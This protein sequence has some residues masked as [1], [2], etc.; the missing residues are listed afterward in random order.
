ML[1]M[2]TR[3]QEARRRTRLKSLLAKERRDELIKMLEAEY[4]PTYLLEDLFETRTTAAIEVLLELYRW[5]NHN[6][7][8]DRRAAY[9]IKHYLNEL[10][11]SVTDTGLQETINRAICERAEQERQFKE[12]CEQIGRELNESIAKAKALKNAIRRCPK[13]G[14]NPT[15]RIESMDVDDSW[16]THYWKVC[17]KCGSKIENGN[18]QVAGMCCQIGQKEPTDW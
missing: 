15:T 2:W 4:Y 16:F 3:F 8:F 1:S 7:C 12:R 14:D 17:T 13:C 9:A 6:E 18:G 11:K 5:D 10:L